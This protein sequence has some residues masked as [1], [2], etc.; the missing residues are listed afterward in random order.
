MNKC[1]FCGTS[2]EE[3]VE[4]GFVG[5]QKCYQEIDELKKA[6]NSLYAGKKH[7]ARR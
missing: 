2:Y 1:P 3:I 7:K 6:I 4:T 5:C